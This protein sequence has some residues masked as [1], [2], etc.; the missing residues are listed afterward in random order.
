MIRA[1]TPLVLLTLAALAF[2]CEDPNAD[3]EGS[4]W[5]A[6]QG[7]PASL[8]YGAVWSFA[9]DNVWVTA[10]GGRVLRYDGNSWSETA[11]G[12]QEMM[13]GIWGF[14]PDDVWMVG[15]QTL[16]RFD[17]TNFT[18]TD[19]AAENAGIEGLTSIWASAPDDVWAG[20]TQST[21]AH[22][23]GSSWTRTIAAGTDNTALW[24]SGPDDVYVVGLFEVAHYNGSTFETLDLGN[25]GSAES[26]FG[27]ASD[28]VWIASGSSDLTH[29]DGN[30]WELIEL[31]RGEP[32]ALWGSAPDDIWGVGHFASITHYDGDEWT[33]VDAQSMGSPF[34]RIF[35]DVHGSAADDI[36]T[37]GVEL[38]EDG[39]LPL[40]W[41]YDGK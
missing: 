31:E 13:L 21:V 2:G 40:V 39:N 12:T 30:A 11:L 5:G 1:G 19:L 7:V 34:L 25:F 9:P 33:E 10:D 6:V 29:W 23:D 16:V 24:G 36:W 38:G 18:V 14:A 4:G 20:G 17:G 41:R 8:S 35:H 15:G 27:F 22:F 37:V 26:V 32:G 28:D 3:D